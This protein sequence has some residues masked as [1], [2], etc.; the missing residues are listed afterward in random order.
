MICLAGTCTWLS[1]EGHTSAHSH[2]VRD[3]ALDGHQRKLR[4]TGAH[5]KPFDPLP[6]WTFERKEPDFHCEQGTSC[7]CAGKSTTPGRSLTWLSP[8]SSGAAGPNPRLGPL[9]HVSVTK[10]QHDQ[11]SIECS[12]WQGRCHN[13]PHHAVCNSSGWHQCH[14]VEALQALL[15][16][17]QVCR[18]AHTEGTGCIGTVWSGGQPVRK[19]T[20]CSQRGV[21]CV[22]SI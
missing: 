1:K 11:G 19:A 12:Y 3:G 15:V 5:L 6:E 14:N 18:D 4:A 9:C 22:S 16:V 20:E 10:G 13:P 8:A 2:W 21:T 17:I 7:R